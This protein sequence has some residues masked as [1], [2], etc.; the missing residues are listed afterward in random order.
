MCVFFF[1][2]VT[3]SE[4]ELEVWKYFM[5]TECCSYCMTHTKKCGH[6]EVEQWVC[7]G[8]EATPWLLIV[9]QHSLFGAANHG[10]T[11][12]QQES[13]ASPTSRFPHARICIYVYCISESVVAL[14]M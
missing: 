13:K 14:S 1:F 5:Y 8:I 12:L 3:H 11:Y 9:Y 10:S 6:S 2:L 4:G 7:S